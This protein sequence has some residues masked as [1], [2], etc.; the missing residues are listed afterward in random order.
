MPSS[1][2]KL[3]REQLIDELRDLHLAFEADEV[4][5]QDF[6][7]RRDHLQAQFDRLQ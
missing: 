1:V 3:Q 5:T 4:S 2:G 6:E 7:E